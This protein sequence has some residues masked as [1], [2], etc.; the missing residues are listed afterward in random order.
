MGLRHDYLCVSPASASL[1]HTLDPSLTGNGH[2]ALPISLPPHPH[3]LLLLLLHL[4]HTRNRS[5]IISS[6]LRATRQL[7]SLS[8]G[9]LQWPLCRSPPPHL[10]S[11]PFSVIATLHAGGAAPPGG[12]GVEG[13]VGV[14]T[15]T[16]LTSHDSRLYSRQSRN[17]RLIGESEEESA[18][19]SLAAGPQRRRRRRYLGGVVLSPLLPSPLW[20]RHRRWRLSLGGS[21]R[22]HVGASV[23]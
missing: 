15:P 4:L 19:F 13:G 22:G 1:T 8:S 2:F 21:S 6:T 3:A 10:R 23:C 16:P 18:L 17:T 5:Q 9:H 7:L 20:W 12:G 14:I 11:G